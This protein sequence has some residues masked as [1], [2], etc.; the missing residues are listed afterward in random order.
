MHRQ[1]DWWQSEDEPVVAGIHRG[2]SE[3][4]SEE[5]PVSRGIVAQDDHMSAEGIRCLPSSSAYGATEA[6]H[7]SVGV[8]DGAFPLAVV[9]VARPVYLYASPSPLVG[10]TPAS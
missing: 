6:D 10:D 1:F 2:E 8:G 4:V 3:H 5:D 9:L 7:V